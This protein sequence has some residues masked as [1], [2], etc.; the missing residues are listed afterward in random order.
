MQIAK[1]GSLTRVMSF[2]RLFR[3]WRQ[4]IH[5]NGKNHHYHTSMFIV[6][7]TDYGRLQVMRMAGGYDVYGPRHNTPHIPTSRILILCAEFGM[8]KTTVLSNLVYESL[9]SGIV[10][11]YIDVAELTS[12]ETHDKIREIARR[13]TKK[14][15]DK[16]NTDYCALI[17]VDNINVEDEYDAGKLAELI[18]RITSSD[19]AIAMS[20]LPESEILVE[21]LGEARCL[22][23]CDLRVARPS[24]RQEAELYDRYVQ[25]IPLLQ[26]A[27]NK[28]DALSIGSVANDPSYQEPYLS[29]V[30]STVRKGMMSEE[31]RLRC[32]MHLLGSGSR[33]DLEEV[34]GTLDDVL[35]RMIAR[36]A[37]FFGVDVIA[38]TF[39]C[40]GSHS[41]DCLSVAYSTL[42]TISHRWPMLVYHVCHRLAMRE[43]YSRAAM[44]GLMCSSDKERCK[45]CFEWA[46]EFIDVGEVNAVIDALDIANSMHDRSIP[47]Y[48]EAA[49]VLISLNGGDLR[50]AE[51]GHAKLGPDDP[52]S[53]RAIMALAC[54]RLLRGDDHEWRYDVCVDADRIA[55]ALNIHGKI[56]SLVIAGRLE[57]AYQ[58]SLESALRLD[59]STI[60]SA[61]VEMDHVLCSFLTGIAPSP[62]DAELTTSAMELFERSG[63]VQLLRTC[64]GICAAGKLLSG[65][66]PVKE[67]FELYI[68]HAMRSKD[69]LLYG[70]YL[71]VAG[72]SDIR[73]SA[74]TRSHVR[75][76]RATKVFESLK[77]KTLAAVSRLFD[78]AVRALLGESIGLFEI[79]ACKGISEPLDDVAE[80]LSAALLT[81]KTKRPTIG[82]KKGCVGCPRDVYWIVN[83]L[84]Y[85]CGSV[86]RRFCK[87][88]P[89]AWKDSV[90]RAAGEIDEYFGGARH[91][92]RG[93]L[94]SIGEKDAPDSGGVDSGELGNPHIEVCVLGGLE[95]YVS[96]VPIPANRLERRRAKS[97]LALLA[98]VPGH[99]VKRYTIMESVWPTHDYQS[100]NK[101]IYSATSV[102]RSEMGGT[103]GDLGNLP[104]IVSNKTEGTV[105]FNVGAITCDV[106][107][108]EEMAH[109]L[110]DTEGADRQ[111]V[112][113]CREIEELYK[114]DLFVPPTDGM[115]IVQTRAR[116][117]RELYADA[118]IAGAYA[119]SNLGMKA[120]ACRF[121]RKAHDVDELR[122]DAVK[123]LVVCLCAVGRHV[124]A[125]RC[126][127][128]FVGRVI[129]VTHRPPSRHL[130]EIVEALI[131]EWA[132]GQEKRKRELGADGAAQVTIA[133][134]EGDALQ[135]QLS[136]DWED[137]EI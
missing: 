130:R 9:K 66:Q 136:F 49:C 2:M 133:G 73:I 70:M 99:V 38:G 88:M 68:Q 8:G 55:E 120:L 11:Y 117:L 12:Q 19:I 90:V 28:V 103:A 96:G 114:G 53:L 113:M 81:P 125:E 41:L 116:E 54:R 23:S 29:V 22:W 132:S 67:S 87:M 128:R 121:A 34:M 97:L 31:K 21:Q 25:G 7:N 137:D 60:T 20:I 4:T 36:D 1:Q 84:S 78:M 15:K 5:A 123:V 74:Y 24:D 16:V 100:A 27:L 115:G 75:I 85:D 33:T 65:R 118:M 32:A 91:I 10:S 105:S 80:I 107:V 110:L 77:A 93:L 109:R 64:E 26:D 104:A 56:L 69:T 18:R 106:D 79:R 94:P 95:V 134:E 86:S 40:V 52:G 131:N 76:V 63:L 98:S 51:Q 72:I 37:P 6:V 71:L 135:R 17:S 48:R 50:E 47:G 108:F 61:I 82:E 35:W 39:C 122:E 89:L 14:Y 126:Y 42:K 58:L 92:A 83:V 57:D 101:C 44:I 46:M 127:E 111:V 43:D 124:E 3:S 102:L 62:M 112:S 30:E 129:D 13:C 119:A 45:I 59:A